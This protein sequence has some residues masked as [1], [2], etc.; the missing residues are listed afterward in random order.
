MKNELGQKAIAGIMEEKRKKDERDQE[1]RKLLISFIEKQSEMIVP[2]I[3]EAGIGAT[4]I[5]LA[6]KMDPD[7]LMKLIPLLM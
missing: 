7:D 5:G 4:G 3:V 6:S 2:P 1:V